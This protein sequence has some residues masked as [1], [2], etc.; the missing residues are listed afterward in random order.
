MQLA[1]HEHHDA[2]NA[3]KN[4][5]RWHSGTTC[6]NFSAVLAA[7]GPVPS[8]HISHQLCSA[9]DQFIHDVALQHLNVVFSQIEADCGD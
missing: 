8:C 2:E 6:G 5:R 4:I 7:E 9:Y 3:Q 1:F